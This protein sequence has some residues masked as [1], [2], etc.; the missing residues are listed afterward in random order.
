MPLTD[1]AEWER[2][3][4]FASPAPF[5]GSTNYRFIEESNGS[6]GSIREDAGRASERFDAV[7]RAA[8]SNPGHQQWS[9]GEGKES[10]SSEGK[11]GDSDEESKER[12]SDDEYR[13][14]PLRYSEAKEGGYG[15]HSSAERHCR[16]SACTSGAAES[17]LPVAAPLPNEV[18]GGAHLRE[19]STPPPCYSASRGRGAASAAESA[20]PWCLQA[21]GKGNLSSGARADP[22]V[23]A[24]PY[25]VNVKNRR[26]P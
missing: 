11:W 14:G 25:H 5:H 9:E 8:S 13:T 12:D 20:S 17:V 24:R 26:I 2:S 7:G 15:T 21:E 16:L 6:G 23:S 1:S 18:L 4:A 10:G 22:E 19:L 3:V